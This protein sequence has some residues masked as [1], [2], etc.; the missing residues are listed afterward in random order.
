[1]RQADSRPSRRTFLGATGTVTAVG[2]SAGCQSRSDPPDRDDA[3]APTPPVS[4]T[5][6]YQAGITLPQPA[7]RNLLAVV[8]DLVD[9][10]PVRPLLAELGEAVRTLTAGIDTRLMGLPPG[11]LTVTIGVGPRLVRTVDPALPGAKDLPRFSREQI[12]SRARGGDLLIQIC[13][14]D[15]LVVPVVAAAL[16]EQAGDR[17]QERWRQSGV[18]GANVPVDRGR[19]APRNLFGFVDGIVGPHTRA[20]QER[21]LWLAGPAPVAGGTL[22]VL[23]RMELDLPRF[24]KLSVPEQEAVFGRRRTTGVP[25]SG[26]SIASGPDLGAK[27]PDGRYLVPA[28]AHARRAHATAVG[29]GLMLRR[30]YSTDGPAPGLLFM[31]FQ[32]DIRTFTNTLTRMDNSDALLEY[33][34]TTAS[35]TFLILPGFDEQHPLGSR[36][37]R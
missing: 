25:L 15:A 22:A 9:A 19:A 30:S 11:D 34:T 36:L 10:V 1:M 16:L 2:L 32:N 8:A 20:E 12:A 14:G 13:A 6:R 26:G 37:F 28:E 33:T 31:S 3:P 24:A 23:R 17:I 5:G 35:A 7:Q 21:D 27:T 4:P 29:V 18:R